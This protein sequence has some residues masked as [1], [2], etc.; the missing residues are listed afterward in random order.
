[1]FFVSKSHI[2]SDY[3]MVALHCAEL[4]TPGKCRGPWLLWLLGSGVRDPSGLFCEQDTQ[5]HT[6][7][8][9]KWTSFQGAPT[10]W[11][12]FWGVPGCS[13]AP[14]TRRGSQTGF[15]QTSLLPP[16]PRECGRAL[17]PA[18][19]PPPHCFTRGWS[20]S[21]CSQVFPLK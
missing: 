3:R 5:V 2:F 9:P 18:G 8:L 20:K 13:S 4:R 7:F 1:M 19:P 6:S 17:Q 12:L 14:A 16:R 11:W 15:P 21:G 10:P